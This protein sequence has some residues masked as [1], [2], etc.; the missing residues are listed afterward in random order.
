MIVLPFGNDNGE[1]YITLCGGC[2]GVE[3]S[4]EFAGLGCGGAGSS[5]YVKIVFLVYSSDYLV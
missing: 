5:T 3:C 4:S 2:C 1:V